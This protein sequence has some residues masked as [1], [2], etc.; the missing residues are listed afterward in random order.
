VVLIPSSGDA[1]RF[2]PRRNRV[3]DQF[4][5]PPTTTAP[6]GEAAAAGP[7]TAAVSTFAL[8]PFLNGIL[9]FLPPFIR[10]FVIGLLTSIFSNPGICRFFGTCASP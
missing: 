9:N 4:L 10:D 1:A 7:S 3:V 6:T 8:P 2:R 5:T